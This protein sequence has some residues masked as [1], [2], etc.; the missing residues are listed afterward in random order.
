MR[1]GHQL[2]NQIIVPMQD[3]ITAVRNVM[4]DACSLSAAAWAYQFY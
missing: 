2:S 4:K 3:I 1:S